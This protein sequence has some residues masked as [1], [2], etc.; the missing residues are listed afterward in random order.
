[1]T[2][3]FFLAHLSSL[4]YVFRFRKIETPSKKLINKSYTDKQIPMTQFI[5]FIIPPDYLVKFL[6][7]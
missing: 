3:L 7:K 4:F 2:W 5:L 6:T 1:M